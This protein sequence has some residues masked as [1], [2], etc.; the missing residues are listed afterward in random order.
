MIKL[1][2][3]YQ[4]SDITIDIEET[5]TFT[6]VQDILENITGIGLLELYD[7]DYPDTTLDIEIPINQ[8][9]PDTHIINLITLLPYLELT[10]DLIDQCRYSLHNKALNLIKLK[11][12]ALKIPFERYIWTAVTNYS[13]LFYNNNMGDFGVNSYNYLYFKDLDQYQI[14]IEAAFYLFDTSNGISFDYTF[15]YSSYNLNGVMNWDLSKGTSFS[16]MFQKSKI[17]GHNIIND[18]IDLNKL[19]IPNNTKVQLS[20]M[21]QESYIESSIA[22]WDISKVRDIKKMCYKSKIELPLLINKDLL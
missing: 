21:F 16:G 22:D 5:N 2:I 3:N 8:I 9:Y 15:N 1:L 10:D 11:E 12:L 20:R 19:I 14:A 7:T 18:P 6:N 13:Y 17:H 4:Q